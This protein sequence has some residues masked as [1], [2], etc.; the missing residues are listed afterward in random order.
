M[1]ISGSMLREIKLPTGF[2]KSWPALVM[3]AI[4]SPVSQMGQFK[5][6]WQE[7]V[8]RKYL[9]AVH[10]RKLDIFTICEELP[11]LVIRC[12]LNTGKK[13]MTL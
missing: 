7:L 8:G 4:R 9:T 10:K 12:D 11:C 5:V 3:I 13:K 2:S 6:V 1:S